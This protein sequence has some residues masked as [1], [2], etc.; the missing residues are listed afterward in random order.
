VFQGGG[1]GE[2]QNIAKK[3]D[4]EIGFDWSCHSWRWNFDWLVFLKSS[5]LA[6]KVMLFLE[7]GIM[8]VI[9]L[10]VIPFRT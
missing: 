5:F 6:Q 8:I 3:E 10:N 7:N 4:K 2:G 9:K 1:E